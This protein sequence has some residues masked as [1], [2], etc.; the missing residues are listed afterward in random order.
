MVSFFVHYVLDRVNNPSMYGAKY[1]QKCG[2]EAKQK[3]Y[4]TPLNTQAPP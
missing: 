1:P 4:S 2:Q 3:T